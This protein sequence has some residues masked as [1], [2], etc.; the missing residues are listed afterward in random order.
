MIGTFIICFLFI[1]Y[2]PSSKSGRRQLI[3]TEIEE[4]LRK[5]L[6]DQT[7]GKQLNKTEQIELIVACSF[8]VHTLRPPEERRKT[9][10]KR[11]SRRSIGRLIKKF[12]LKTSTAEI[13]N[14]SRYVLV[15]IVQYCTT[16]F[17]YSLYCSTVQYSFSHDPF[18]FTQV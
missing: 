12:N 9:P 7:P 10:W 1:G 6:L 17:E 15:D 16:V 4:S 13:Q 14:L 5:R 2:I 3:P 18:V 8:K 11:P